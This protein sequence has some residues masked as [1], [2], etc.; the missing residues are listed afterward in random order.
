MEWHYL[1]YPSLQD[2]ELLK[3]ELRW[4]IEATYRKSLADKLCVECRRELELTND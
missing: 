1:P 2:R 4:E 3:A